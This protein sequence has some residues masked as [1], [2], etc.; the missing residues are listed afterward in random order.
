MRIGNWCKK[1]S[2]T[3]VAAGIFVP[4]ITYADIIPIK[5]KDAGFE[6]YRVP[7]AVGYAYAADPFG[8]YRPTSAW[9]DDLDNSGGYTQDDSDSNW[10]YNADYAEVGGTTGNSLR[11]S[12]IGGGRRQAMHTNLN[13]NAQVT[14]MVFEAGNTY[15]FTLLAQGDADASSTSSRIWLYIFNGANPFNGGSPL[16]ADFYQP[17]DGDF[18]NRNPLWTPEQS[19]A[20]WTPI[21]LSWTVQEGASEIGSPIGVAFWGRADGAVDTLVPEPSTIILVGLGGVALLALRRK[22]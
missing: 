9:V 1:L 17:A 21:T 12:P 20:N 10:L 7:K 6:D 4:S 2:A 16:V 22:L 8:A 3:L 13:Y 11:P 15:T 18:V 19:Q 5:F 14:N